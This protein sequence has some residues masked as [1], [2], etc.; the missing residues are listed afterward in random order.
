MLIPLTEVGVAS[1]ALVDA[2][3]VAAAAEKGG[4]AIAAGQTARLPRSLSEQALTTRLAVA[5][6]CFC[7]S[8]QPFPMTF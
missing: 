7:S 4:A 3:T 1:V 8:S 6:N 5:N 2:A